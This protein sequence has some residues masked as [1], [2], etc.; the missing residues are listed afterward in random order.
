MKTYTLISSLGFLATHL[1]VKACGLLIITDQWL[2]GSGK[3]YKRKLPRLY[4]IL[5]YV[6]KIE[7]EIDTQVPRPG[8]DVYG[9]QCVNGNV[10]R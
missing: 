10:L 5:V 4:K 1:M 2:K 6:L 7:L 8:R 9:G 3:M